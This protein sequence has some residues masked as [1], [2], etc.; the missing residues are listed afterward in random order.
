MRKREISDLSEE[1]P[2]AFPLSAAIWLLFKLTARAYGE[3]LKTAT[4]FSSFGSGQDILRLSC[5]NM[6]ILAGVR[7][8]GDGFDQHTCHVRHT[9]T[10]TKETSVGICER[11]F[12]EGSRILKL[13]L[14]RINM[15]FG[16][17]ERVY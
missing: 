4:C 1:F 3:F 12:P 9:Q 13:K 17:K 10:N 8:D 6:V 16:Q 11:L 2:A 7:A 15:V 14:T 5:P